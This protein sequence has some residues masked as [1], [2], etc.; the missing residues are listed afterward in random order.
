[1]LRRAIVRVSLI[2]AIVAY[3]S[4]AYA[5]VTIE[6]VPVGNPGNAG[7]L[8]GV[9]AG[10]YGPDRI[11]GEVDY[12]QYCE[13]L[14]AKAATNTYG[15]YSTYMSSSPRGGINRSG[16][17]GSYTYSVKSGYE[18]M[19]VVYVCCF[20]AMRFANWL[21]NGQGSGSTET[22]T[23]T[24]TDGGSNSGTVAVPNAATRATWTATPHWVLP[25][26]DEWYKAAYHQPATQGGDSDNYW[27]YPTAT[28]S[29]PHS[30]NPASLNYPTNSANFYQDDSEANG[31]DDG[32]AVT[33]STSWGNSKN[34]L[35]NV[36]AYTL[37]DSFYGTFDQAGNVWEWNDTLIGSSRGN[38]GGSW[39]DYSNFIAASLRDSDSPSSENRV[40]GFR[41]ASVPEPGSIVIM[42]A[43]AISL[44]AYAWHRRRA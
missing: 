25:S 26:E 24:I 4:A 34:Y 42:L 33:G 15:L 12:A 20:D 37:S 8:S 38:R 32:F 35:T 29:V 2:A 28:N 36:G 11:C 7:E 14:N 23:Y 22:G 19:P 30:D 27:L 5:V 31:Y 3:A 41:V 39:F 1:V 16:S 18:N 17:S 44:L 13:F 43:A 9:G 10:G 21:Q 40:V 6:T